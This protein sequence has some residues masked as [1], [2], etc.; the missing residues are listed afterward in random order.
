ML[1]NNINCGMKLFVEFSSNCMCA[2]MNVK[3]V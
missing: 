2:C 1:Y 3:P